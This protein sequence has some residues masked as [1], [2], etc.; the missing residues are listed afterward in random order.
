MHKTHLTVFNN[1]FVEGYVAQRPEGYAFWL[2]GIV[3]G[4]RTV[5]DHHLTHDDIVDH[6]SRVIRRTSDATAD[7]SHLA[8]WKCKGFSNREA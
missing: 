6:Y 2:V 8:Q 3:D 7:F 1:Q 5:L 4:E